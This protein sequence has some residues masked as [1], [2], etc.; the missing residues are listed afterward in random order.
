LSEYDRRLWQA[1]TPVF[2]VDKRSVEH[3][4][5]QVMAVIIR[6][7]RFDIMKVMASGSRVVGSSSWRMRLFST[8]GSAP[9]I[10][11]PRQVPFSCGSEK[12]CT[13]VKSTRQSRTG[14]VD[15]SALQLPRSGA[16]GCFKGDT[17][18]F[19]QTICSTGHPPGC[20]ETWHQA[21]D[22]ALTPLAFDRPA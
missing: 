5:G 8:L 14:V 21:C 9:W 10:F 3:Q 13:T 7:V 20:Q 18:R 16:S 4:M 12:P 6:K 19:A 22:L 11:Q 2:P 1:R 15:L 17:G